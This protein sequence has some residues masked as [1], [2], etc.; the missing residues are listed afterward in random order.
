[1][2]L[3]MVVRAPPAMGGGCVADDAAA[4]AELRAIVAAAHSR[5]SWCGRGGGA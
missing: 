4:S 5:C 1:L 2:N 3:K